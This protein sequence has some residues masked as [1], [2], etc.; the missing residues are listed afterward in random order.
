MKIKFEELKAFWHVLMSMPG[1]VALAT[2]WE[3]QTADAVVFFCMEESNIVFRRYG[4]NE[5][6]CVTIGDIGGLVDLQRLFME[7]GRL[8]SQEEYAGKTSAN[9]SMFVEQSKKDHSMTENLADESKTYE[10]K[11]R[12]DSKI[13]YE[14]VVDNFV[15]SLRLNQPGFENLI[16]LLEA[17]GL[18]YN[19][20]GSSDSITSIE[21][22]YCHEKVAATLY[23]ADNV[24]SGVVISYGE[25]GYLINKSVTP[26]VAIDIAHRRVSRNYFRF[27]AG[28]PRYEMPCKHPY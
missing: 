17:K 10:S 18:N 28:D 3:V 6:R 1:V 2:G 9:S 22:V 27:H 13:V 11:D 7:S 16:K 25:R 5:V 15:A 24:A 14:P 23:A 20:N 12:M 19:I 4:T 8:F 21:V 26:E